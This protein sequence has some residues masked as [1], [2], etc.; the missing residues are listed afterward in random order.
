MKII[1]IADYK[2]N[3]LPITSIITNAIFVYYTQYIFDIFVINLRKE[4]KMEKILCYFI[5][6]PYF[7]HLECLVLYY[8]YWITIKDHFDVLILLIH[9]L[10]HYFQK[11]VHNHV[12]ISSEKFTLKVSVYLNCIRINLRLTFYTFNYMILYVSN[13]IFNAFE[14]IL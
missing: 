12:Y 9:I 5:P 6:I 11:N 1:N 8:V 13:K 2:I 14:I 10:I 7:W 3:I 4:N